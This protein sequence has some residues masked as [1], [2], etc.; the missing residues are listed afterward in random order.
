LLEGSAN[1]HGAFESSR[2]SDELIAEARRGMAALL[3]AESEHEI[4][5][6]PNMT[7]LTY[8]LSRAIARRFVPGDEVIVSELDHDANV[9]PWLALEESGVVVRQIPMQ[10]DDCTLDLAAYARLL[11]PKTRLVAVG[12]ASNAVG[13]INDVERVVELAHRA[14]ALVWVDA[15]HYAPHGLIDVTALGADFVVCS[16]YKFFGPHLGILWG[17]ASVL[18]A[19]Q[20][21][22]VRPAPQTSPEKFETG[23][24]NHECIAGLLQTLDY[25]RELGRRA[26]ATG[27]DA[28]SELARAMQAIRD[29]ENGLGAALLDGLSSVSGLRL[30]GID[31]A[32]RLHERVPTFAFTLDGV[33]SAEVSERLG[34]RGI[35][36]WAGNYYALLVMQ[37]LGLTNGAVR[38]GAVHYNSL[39]EID[40]L[41]EA[42]KDL[43]RR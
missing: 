25:L 41:I 29:Y 3:G 9:S 32:S 31:D 33:P 10:V 11:S 12:Y 6:G 36:S 16:A 40:R 34:D 17:K 8:A 1:T 4:A 5:F 35:Y 28:R 42:L 18:D 21:H 26:G 43:R 22:Q 30:Y 2:R 7:T 27:T 23:T 19:V 37:R 14:G 39:N 13:T 38:V 24:K 15:V 20:A